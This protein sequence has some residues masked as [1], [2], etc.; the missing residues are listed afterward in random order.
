VPP[1]SVLASAGRGGI[2]SVVDECH[3]GHLL[4]RDLS[5]REFLFRDEDDY[6][7]KYRRGPANSRPTA[8]SRA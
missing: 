3:R 6:I 2:V 8:A 7:S 4:D 5:D 1:V